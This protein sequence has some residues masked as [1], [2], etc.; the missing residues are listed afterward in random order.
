MAIFTLLS[1]K[2]SI[3]LYINEFKLFNQYEVMKSKQYIML[4]DR[5][6]LFVHFIQIHQEHQMKW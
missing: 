5:K 6:D 3:M 2:L 1:A 4:Y